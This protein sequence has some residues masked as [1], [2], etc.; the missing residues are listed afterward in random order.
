MEQAGYGQ[1]IADNIRSFPF[2]VPIYTDEIA[3]DVAGQFRI[4][5]DQAK[6]LVNVNLKRIAD[7]N[8][9]E[10][11]QKGIYYKAQET[12]FGK[13]KLNTAQ[14][15]R[16]MY[17]V[18]DGQR[19]GYETGHSFF[20]RIGLTTQLP[21]Y[22]TYATNAFRQK[23]NRVE[24]KLGVILR[25]PQAEVTNE[26]YHYLQFLDVIENREKIAVDALEPEQT[27]LEYIRQNELDY[28]RLAGYASQY[29]RKEVLLRLGELAA[30]ALIETTYR[31]EGI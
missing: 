6:I 18:R 30:G 2:G 17:L 19:I 24:E 8:G 22:K 5:L 29:Y 10:R 3:R 1:Y 31:P 20:N 12:P 23:G 21:K 16:D 11:Y 13:T 27:L 28:F 25:R 9:L 4:E 7:N 26:N 14:V 15:M